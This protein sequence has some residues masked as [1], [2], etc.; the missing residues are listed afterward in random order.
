MVKKID[1]HIHTVSSN[2]DY[3][4]TY[5]SNWIQNYVKQANLDAIA[6]TNHDLFDVDNF[7]KVKQDLPNTTVFPGIE[8]SLEDDHV[9][10]I[11]SE[12]NIEHLKN[13]SEWLHNQNENKKLLTEDYCKNMKCW[14][15]AIYIFEMGKSNSL[16]VPKIIENSSATVVGGV[17]NQLKFQALYN[18]DNLITPVL[19]SDAHAAKNDLEKERNDIDLLKMKNTYL[20]IDNCT[21]TEIKNC[22]A[23]KKGINTNKD[24]LSNIIEIQEH[25]VSTGM[26][27]I[28]GKR[29]TGKSKFLKRIKKQYDPEDY[30]AIDQFETAQADKYIEK[31]RKVQGNSSFNRWKR[32]Y[33]IQFNAIEEYLNRDEYEFEG[34]V[35]QYLDSV[36]KFATDNAKSRSKSKF[37]LNKEIN[38][39]MIPIQNLESHITKIEQLLKSNDLWTL[40]KNSN[41]K[42]KVFIETYNELRNMFINK[43]LKNQIKSEVNKILESVKKTVQLNTGITPIKNCDF[44]PIIQKA[45]IEKEIINFMQNIITEQELM[46]EQIYDYQ[47]V[48]KISP[49]QNASQFKTDISTSDAVKDDIIIPY[50]K[51]EYIKFL[52]NLKNKSFFKV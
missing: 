18:Q 38:F 9:N 11:F 7:N 10:I 24:N 17:S 23:N 47:I 27:L 20:Q 15:D 50:Q 8:L 28:V 41:E 31:Q 3:E 16:S 6:I 52:K 2:K 49:F 4:F 21:F 35:E 32:Q 46:R 1:F 12:K 13:F 22:M 44:S 37:R 45:H 30:Y 25:N 43:K 42:R 40:L 36:K 19:F 26:N 14:K 39:E 29:G 33:E 51:K 48:V 34:K 5:S